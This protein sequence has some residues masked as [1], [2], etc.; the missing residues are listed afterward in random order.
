MEVYRMFYKI[1]YKLARLW[2]KGEKYANVVNIKKAKNLGVQVGN[3]CRFYSTDFSSEPY[4][5]E[6]GNHVTIT[7]GVRFVTHDGAAWVIR[8]L[9]DNYKNVNILGKIKIG[10][11]VFIGFNSIILPGV[12]IGDNTV[13]AAGSVVTKSFKGNEVIAGLPAKSI[14]PLDGYIDLNKDYLVNTKNL[15]SSQKKDFIL[16]DMKK[17]QFR[18]K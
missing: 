8:G 4:L 3:N 9:G 12:T 15:S 7:S 1:Y 2:Y 18:Q 13:I 11:N 5:I 10:N 6:I 16:N 14:K 17:N